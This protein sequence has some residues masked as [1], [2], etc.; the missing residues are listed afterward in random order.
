MIEQLNQILLFASCFVLSQMACHDTS[1]AFWY[2]NV[3]GSSLLL[4]VLEIQYYYE[5]MAYSQSDKTHAYEHNKWRWQKR[6]LDSLLGENQHW[7][8]IGAPSLYQLMHHQQHPLYHSLCTYSHAH[9]HI[10]KNVVVQS[11]LFLFDCS[12]T[13]KCP[14]LG[15]YLLSCNLVDMY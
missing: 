14:I 11:T 5:S 8:C 10:N 3:F 2:I 9:L 15:T 13:V 1:N 6:Y 4:T 7:S 12:Y